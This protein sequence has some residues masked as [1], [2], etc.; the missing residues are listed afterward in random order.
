MINGPFTRAEMLYKGFDPNQGIV[1]Y[2]PLIGHTVESSQYFS[3]IVT[4]EVGAE[5]KLDGVDS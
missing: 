3:I 4:R 1:F 2:R 5:G